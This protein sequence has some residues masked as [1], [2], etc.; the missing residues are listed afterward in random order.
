MAR[1]KIQTIHKLDRHQNSQTHKRAVQRLLETQIHP[2]PGG[3]VAEAPSHPPPGADSTE[4]AFNR[5][6]TGGET[7]VSHIQPQE[8]QLR[9]KNVSHGQV[10]KMLEVFQEQ[11]S[12]TSFERAIEAGRIMGSDINPGNGSRTVGR[13]LE[14]IC[15]RREI[16]VNRSLL[17]ECTVLGLGQDGRDSALLVASRMVMAGWV[18]AA[19]NSQAC[20]STEQL[21]SVAGTVVSY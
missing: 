16:T 11:N 3:H 18:W 15:A 5:T 20:S 9:E 7:P 21:S 17:R 1:C 6:S 13:N 12:I 19:C 4:S 10:I 14:T 2:A 8:T